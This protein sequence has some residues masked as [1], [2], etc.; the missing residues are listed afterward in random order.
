MEYKHSGQPSLNGRGTAKPG[1][2]KHADVPAT[3]LPGILN[4]LGLGNRPM[5]G[6]KQAIAALRDKQSHVRVAAVRSLGERRDFSSLQFLLFALH[7]PA[8]EIRVAAVWALREFG[9][10]APAQA[11]V[12]AL[13]DEDGS[14]CA[15]ALRVLA[16]VRGRVPPDRLSRM[17]NDTDALVREAAILTLEELREQEPPEYLAA[18]L[19][20]EKAVEPASTRIPPEQ[21][22]ADALS[23]FPFPLR[24]AASL[25]VLGDRYLLQEPIGRGGM[26]T[27]YRGWDRKME[28]VVAIKVLREVYNTDAKFVARFQL[29]EKAASA[30]QHPHIVQVYD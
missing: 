4:H 12:E 27:I 8:W 6:S 11:L 17:L 28:R 13:A 29:E 14:V 9:E 16:G 23:S 1:S 20:N 30:L 24:K 21:P 26:A 3:L 7:D 5:A 19:R 15:A 22:H 10:Q 18:S 2:Q 25:E